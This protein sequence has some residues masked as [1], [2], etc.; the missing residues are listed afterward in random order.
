MVRKIKVI[1]VYDIEP[2]TNEEANEPINDE[3][4]AEQASEHDN[5]QVEPLTEGEC[6]Y[7]TT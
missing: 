3:Q 7:R 4:N 5:Q 1:D 2:E 6:E